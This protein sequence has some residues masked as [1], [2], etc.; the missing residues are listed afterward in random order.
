MS[1]TPVRCR[2]RCT[3]QARLVG[4]RIYRGVHLGKCG[5]ARGLEGYAAHLAAERGTPAQIETIAALHAARLEL[6]GADDELRVKTNR[7]FHE[8][9]IQ[10]S[11]NQRMMDAIYNL[12]QF[13]FNAPVARLTTEG[14][15]A[16][17]NADHASGDRI[18]NSG[19]GLATFLRF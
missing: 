17:G 4:P 12:G 2:P 5:S 16:Q 11:G 10:A 13:Y 8:A 19:S 15:L 18:W 9:I 1:A 6:R 7:E 3:A 14:E